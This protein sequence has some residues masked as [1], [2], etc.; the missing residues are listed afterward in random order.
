LIRALPGKVEAALSAVKKFPEVK[1]VS[2][3]FGRYDI[4]A[5]AEAPTYEAVSALSG[6]MNGIKEV[7]STETLI[8]G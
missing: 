4:V 7:K 5:Y 1:S 3:V 6:K 8:E 2:C